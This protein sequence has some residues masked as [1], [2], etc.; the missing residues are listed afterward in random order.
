MK[1]AMSCRHASPKCTSEVYFDNRPSEAVGGAAFK[2][3][4]TAN[5][6]RETVYL[7]CGHGHVER[8][9]VE[10]DDNGNVTQVGS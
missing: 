3:L 10:I 2:E 5:M 7:E 1:L 8:Y 6:R 9:E 4:A